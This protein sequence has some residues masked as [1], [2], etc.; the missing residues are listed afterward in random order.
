[1]TLAA[2][3]NAATSAI[4]AGP[5]AQQGAFDW[6]SP[7]FLIDHSGPWALLV[8]CAIIFAET[9]LLIGFI[10]PGDSLLLITGLLVFTGTMRGDTGHGIRLDIWIVCL[11]IS[12]AAFLGGELGYWIGHKGGPAVFERKESGVFS[13]KNVERTNAFFDRWGAAAVILARFVPVVRTVGPLMAGVGHMGYKKY[14]L[15]N[16]IG[17]LAWGSGITLIG[18]FIGYIPPLRDFVT[19]Y[20]DIILVGVVVLTAAVILTHYLV[21]SAQARRDRGRALT[22][23][24]AGAVVPDLEDD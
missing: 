22:E 13:I 1:M 6:L 16:A 12:A 19:Q 17:A 14:S 7:R 18:F 2:A 21:T 10:F 23:T 9:G 24:E 20:I 8:V 15:Y 5:I 11:A 4:L 3:F